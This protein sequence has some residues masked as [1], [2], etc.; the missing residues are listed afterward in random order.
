MQRCQ[1]PPCK[2]LGQ[3]LSIIVEYPLC[4]K[5]FNHAWQ[6]EQGN[7]KNFFWEEPCNIDLYYCQ[8]I[9]AICFDIKNSKYISECIS[10]QAYGNAQCCLPQKPPLPPPG[11]SWYEDWETDCYVAE[12]CQCPTKQ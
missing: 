12:S 10:A 6:D 3:R 9:M 7:W 1:F 2:P 8:Y 11:L 5:T 4:K